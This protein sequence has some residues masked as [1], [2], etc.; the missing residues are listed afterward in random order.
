MLT[1]NDTCSQSLPQARQFAFRRATVRKLEQTQTF[2]IGNSDHRAER[3]VDSLRKQRTTR[4][5]SP[6]AGW[7]FTKNLRERFAE[8]ALRSK[9]A[10]IS[11]CI[12]ATAV[13]HVAQGQSHSARAMISLKRHSVMPFELSPRGRR[14]N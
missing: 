3:R 11:R 13:T 2:V 10:A 5:G 4:Y 6:E 7:G 8:T 9:T 14:I 1:R 12:H